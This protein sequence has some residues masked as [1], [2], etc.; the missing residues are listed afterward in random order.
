M[1]KCLAYSRSAALICLQGHIQLLIQIALILNASFFCLLI[2]FSFSL[3]FSSPSSLSHSQLQ[4]WLRSYQPVTRIYKREAGRQK[5]TADNHGISR[6]A[7]L[8]FYAGFVWRF[9]RHRSHLASELEGKC[10]RWFQHHNSYNADARTVDGLHV[11]QHRDVQL[12]PEILRSVSPCLH[13]DCT[14]YHGNVLHP[15]SLWDLHHYSWNEMHKFGR[16]PRQQKSHLFCWRSLLH[17]RRNFWISTDL[18]VHERNHFQF[19]GPDHSRKR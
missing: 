11:V 5:G 4:P 16:G 10:R 7:V 8:C 3:H 18:L 17:S 13:P 2:S 14:N 1:T 6:S 19:S 12:Y 9:W 15:I